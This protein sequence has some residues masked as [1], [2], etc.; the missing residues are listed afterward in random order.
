MF[1]NLYQEAALETKKNSSQ[2]KSTQRYASFGK[3]NSFVI[4]LLDF[5]KRNVRE[6]LAASVLHILKFL[7]NKEKYGAEPKI[8]ANMF[9]TKLHII[10]EMKQK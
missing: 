6:I 5:S 8:N 10:L 4:S 2:K 1:H 3:K 7:S 9:A